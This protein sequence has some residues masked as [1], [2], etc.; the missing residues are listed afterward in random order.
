MSKL[1]FPPDDD[2]KWQRIEP[3]SIGWNKSKLD[4][5]FSYVS[6]RNSHSALMLHKGKII[7]EGAW[8]DHTISTPA[9]MYSGQK[10]VVTL[11]LGI[12]QDK[13]L[14][15]INDKVSDFLE[16]GWTNASKDYEKKITLRHLMTMTSGLND[17]LEEVAG[18]GSV[19]YYN[20][21]AY[22]MLKS[23]LG[24]VAG[25][26]VN[27]F[28]RE[29]LF[30]PI[31]AIN[32]KWEPR[33]WHELPDGT[34]ATGLMISA[35]DMARFGLLIQANG[36]WHGQDIIQDKQFLEDALSSSQPLNPAYG[37]LWWLNGKSNFITALNIKGQGPLFKNA[38]NDSVA[39]LGFMNQIIYI[40]NKSLPAGPK[41]I[42]HYADSNHVHS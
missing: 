28:S 37:Y 42:L 15:N 39:A 27:F 23:V 6:E 41:S 2:E 16:E 34:I 13:G 20:T 26:D 31:G 1:Y 33:P 29:W 7:A 38:P 18:L 12:A 40:C 14:L 21:P 36:K 4:E 8:R 10:S 30:D 35:C 5:L 3:K 17:N 24:I 19:W 25:K 11:L 9:D 32:T 22:H